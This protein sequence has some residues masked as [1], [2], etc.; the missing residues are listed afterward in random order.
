M[1]RN[2]EMTYYGIIHMAHVKTKNR[3]IVLFHIC[4]ASKS[5]SI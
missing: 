5:K 3:T 2:R 4:F 1:D